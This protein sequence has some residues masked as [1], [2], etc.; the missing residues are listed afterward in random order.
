MG[1]V[2]KKMKQYSLD[3]EK[4]DVIKEVLGMSHKEVKNLSLEEVDE[5]LW[6]LEQYQFFVQAQLNRIISKKMAFKNKC[7][8]EINS[9]LKDMEGNGTLTEKR[10]RILDERPDLKDLLQKYQSMQALAQLLV[11]VPKAIQDMIIHLRKVRESREQKHLL[12]EE[13]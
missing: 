13:L 11:D 9:S 1:A 10:A 5:K 8:R 12:G 7:D 4:P 6:V 3:I 2:E